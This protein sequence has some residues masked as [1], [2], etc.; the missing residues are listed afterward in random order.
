MNLRAERH[1]SR[2]SPGAS[3]EPVGHVPRGREG[4]GERCPHA[5]R[6]VASLLAVV[7]MSI[8]LL[9]LMVGLALVQTSSKSI[10][11]QLKY[12]GH[13]INVARAGTTEA[14]TWFQT[15][16]TQPVTA[17]APQRNLSALP[18]V[19]E[20]ENA[21]IGIVRT[22]RVS[23]VGNVW[24]RYEVRTPAVI[25]VTTQ[26]GKTG[27]GTIWQLDSS[28]IVFFDRNGDSQLTWSDVNGNG[29]YY[30]GEPGEVMALTK[31]RAELQRLSVVLPGGNAVL[32]S[33]TCSGIN[34]S[35]GSST[36]R[37]LG[38]TAGSAIACRSGS[39]TPQ[40]GG[41]KVTGNPAV[42]SSVSPYDDSVSSIF[43]LTQDELVAA[44]NIKVSDVASLPTPL[45]GMSLIVVRGNATFTTAHPL[46]GS[47]ILVVFGNLTVPAGS[48]FS[49]VIY[50]SGNYAQ[51]GPSLISGA[52]VAHGAVVLT[53]GG[54]ITE[55]DWDSTIVQQVR[56]TLG[57]YRFSR[58]EYVVP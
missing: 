16:S 12:Q 23:G 8:V 44:A 39:G 58:T 5:E 29:V 14:L 3:S 47:G 45:P 2:W 30:R 21:S 50:V 27:A 4:D 20:T 25:D 22:F 37:V 43:S 26:R 11:G 53:G 33:Y 56:N 54:D 31:V 15:R 1:R 10:A 40:I 52:V 6:G 24:G 19:N 18:P 48:N 13:A 35:S 32:Q 28:G 36:N 7:G 17:F 42:S 49:G 57:G 41:A 9:I 46:A 38:S 51:S 34:L 55:A